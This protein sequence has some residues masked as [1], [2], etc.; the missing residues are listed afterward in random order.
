M[1]AAKLP[2][3]PIAPDLRALAMLGA[4]PRAP[5][6][7]DSE[8]TQRVAS[9]PK[10]DYADNALRKTFQFAN[11]YETMAFVN[12]IAYVAHRQDH[13]PDLV[14][15]YGSVTVAFSTHDAGGV[16]LNDFICAAKIETLGL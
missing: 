5:L 6:L 12:A 10:W 3:P 15:K 16:T 7:A 11:Y 13:H 1:M 4:H 14:V 8:V 2:R 9:L